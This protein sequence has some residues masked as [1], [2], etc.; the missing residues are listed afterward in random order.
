[1]NKRK[2]VYFNPPQLE[3]MSTFA[4]ITI[5]VGGRR[6]GKSF[7][8]LAPFLLL[9]FQRMPGCSIGIV[10]STYKRGLTNTLPGTLS[11]FES[12]GYKR[13]IHYY[14]GRKPPKSAGFEKPIIEPVDYSYVISFYNGS[15]AYIISQDRP[16]SS[17]GLTLDG[18]LGDEAKYL[19]NEKLKEETFPANGGTKK[20]FGD[21]YYHHAMMFAS[22]MPVT[23][24]G[25]WFLNYE[26][27]CDP[28]LIATI[29]GIVYE[30]WNI[31]NRIRD[32]KKKNI[33]PPKYLIGYLKT[34]YRDLARLRRTAVFYK[35]YSSIYNIEILG[36]NYIKQMKRDLTP[37][38]FH[39]SIL[40]KRLGISRDGFYSSMREHHKYT[41]SN[42]SYLEKLDYNFDLIGKDSS[43]QDGDLNKEKPICI[44]MDYNSNINWIVAGQQDGQRIRVLKSF[45][46]KYERKLAEL[47]DDF[48][49]YYRYHQ[50]KEVVYFYDTTALGSNYAV[51]DQ[52]FKY[53]IEHQFE[54]NDWKVHP[55]YVGNP[56]KHHEKY[57]L[58]NRMFAGQADNVPYINEANNEDLLV[59]I[60][61][62]GVYNGKKDKRGEK[63]AE[64]EEDKL[65]YRTDGTDAFDTL[66]IGME[67]FPYNYTPGFW[68]PSSFM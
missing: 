47:V 37:L 15:I 8:L 58:I 67:R 62:T 9:L 33:E 52:D 66:L 56:M 12:W 4:N 10:V 60:E 32:F 48:C 65:E 24:K 54:K 53:V 16:G 6:L 39:T 42:N 11:A 20:Y 21:K 13:N 25:S 64:T 63:L 46:V 18:L 29:Q 1:M 22:D 49:A 36:E 68:L 27:E 2:K 50:C 40:C 31:K 30:T 57:L 38:T 45:Y 34:L 51:N 44:G 41:L 26:K 35:E 19:D 28:E 7:G 3:V 17:N 59:A 23:K 14:I 43:L 61:T 5:F 55:V